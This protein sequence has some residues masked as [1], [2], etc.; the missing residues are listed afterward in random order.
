MNIGL[1]FDNTIV[2][3]DQAISFLADKIFDLPD[4]V[5][6]TK[7]GVRDYLRSE[8]R[9][10]EWTAFQ[11]EL[12]GPGMIYAQPFPESIIT[13][14]KLEER[15]HNLFIIS[16]RSKLP[17]AGKRHDLH[18]A[19]RNWISTRLQSAGL[20]KADEN[21]INFLETKKDKIKKIA[22]TMCDVFVDDLPDILDCADF[23]A[24]TEGILFSPNVP[25]VNS[26]TRRVVSTWKEI[27]NIL[28]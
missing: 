19:A 22:E 24:T 23:P 5:N 18:E 9:E 21:A 4:D 12:Y 1:D 27:T 6:R 7:I 3:Y 13:M 8:G 2:C 11:G 10:P 14:K 26:S 25:V 15:G 28:D 17:Y 16:H 20:F